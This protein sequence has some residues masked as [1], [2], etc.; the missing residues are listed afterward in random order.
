MA[1]AMIQV[2]VMGRYPSDICGLV[3]SVDPC[4]PLV[5]CPITLC[6]PL[7]GPQVVTLWYR[8]P[9][10]SAPGPPPLPGSQVVTLWYRAPSPS[11]PVPPPLP[12]PQVVTLWYR[13]PEILLGTKTYST[14]VDVWSIGCIFAEMINHKPLFPGDSVRQGRLLQPACYCPLWFPACLLLPP[15]GSQPACYCPLWFPACLLLPPL[16]PSL[17][18]TAPSGSQQVM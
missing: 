1:W 12:G 2:V 3:S 5:T 16:V 7:P 14:P 13:A 15:S 8:A 17:P 10:P 4:V 18:A 6:P 11:A 9:S